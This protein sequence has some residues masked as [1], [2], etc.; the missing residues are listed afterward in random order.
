MPSIHLQ[1]TLPDEQ[2]KALDVSGAV[3]DRILGQP[4]GSFRKCGWF[5]ALADA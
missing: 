3:A 2:T 1:P 4:A 5:E